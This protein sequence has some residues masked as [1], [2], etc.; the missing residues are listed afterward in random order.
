MRTPEIGP[1]FAEPDVSKGKMMMKRKM[2]LW[3]QFVGV[4]LLSTPLLHCGDNPE[5]YI[6]GKD[7]RSE[8]LKTA[9][10]E[11]ERDGQLVKR[12]SPE[13][14][15]SVYIPKEQ[16]EAYLYFYSKDRIHFTIGGYSFDKETDFSQLIASNPNQNSSS[17]LKFNCQIFRDGYIQDVIV[18]PGKVKDR[19]YRWDVDHAHAHYPDAKYIVS[20]PFSGESTKDVHVSEIAPD[21]LFQ[22]I[23][24]DQLKSLMIKACDQGINFYPGSEVRWQV[25]DYTNRYLK[26]ATQRSQ[27]NGRVTHPLYLRNH[28]LFVKKDSGEL[29]L[30]EALFSS[31]IGK[32]HNVRPYSEG[33]HFQKWTP[34][35]NPIVVWVDRE[36]KQLR[37]SYHGVTDPYKRDFTVALPIKKASLTDTYAPAILIETDGSKLKEKFKGFYQGPIA[38]NVSDDFR[39]FERFLTAIVNGSTHN[40]LLKLTLEEQNNS[41]FYHS[42]ELSYIFES[43]SSP[44]MNPTLVSLPTLRFQT[45]TK[46]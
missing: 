10:G 13:G 4:G 16:Q 21:S 36:K 3:V 6:S 19:K 15:V 23:P 1:L 20:I 41:V 44:R 8:F 45:E 28:T 2:K 5:K 37:I 35:E 14:H 40:F 29:D 32:M 7:I 34:A 39:V 12:I 31:M 9:S 22:H 27:Y 43:T 25:A 42:V 17:S 24:L 33:G 11:Y 38:S 26:M 46:Q 18:V 30:T